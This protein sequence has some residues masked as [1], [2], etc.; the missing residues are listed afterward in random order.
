MNKNLSQFHD[1]VDGLENKLNKV[2]YPSGFKRFVTS[3]KQICAKLINCLPTINVKVQHRASEKDIKKSLQFSDNKAK[4]LSKSEENKDKLD[5]F[6]KCE[7]MR[8]KSNT[9]SRM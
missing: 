4:A 3:I 8:V 1:M 6:S 2:G 9:K 5:S 7:E